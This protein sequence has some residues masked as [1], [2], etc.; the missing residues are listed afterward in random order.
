MNDRHK[1]EIRAPPLHVAD[2][3]VG[4]SACGALFPTTDVAV[5]NRAGLALPQPGDRAII[6][7]SLASERLFCSARAVSPGHRQH[8]RS[9]GQNE[10]RRAMKRVRLFPALITVF[11]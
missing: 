9:V 10:R 4:A 6:T 1:T 5:G 3:V 11:L 8:E 2:A 7:Q